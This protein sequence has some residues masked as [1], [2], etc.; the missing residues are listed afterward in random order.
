MTVSAPRGDGSLRHDAPAPSVAI[1]VS[2]GIVVALTGVRPTGHLVVDVVET[3][4]GVAI[5]VL[6]GARAPWWLLV[7]AA[8]LAGAVGLSMWPVVV[9]V[10][11]FALAAWVSPLDHDADAR[12]DLG[13]VSVG[14]TLIAFAL[15]NLETFTGASAIAGIGA[16]LALVAGGLMHLT[17]PTRRRLL[18]ATGVVVLVGAVATA[19]L[20]YA[21]LG[22]RDDLRT[23]VD[24]AR[25][26]ARL[27]SDLESEAGANEMR[28]AGA[29][30]AAANGRLAAWYTQPARLVPIVAQHRRAGAD[31]TGE[32]AEQ[33]EAAASDL[34]EISLDGLQIT[35]GT[36]DIASVEALAAPVARFGD[37][38]ERLAGLVDDV[39][40]PW[41]IDAVRTRVGNLDGELSDLLPHIA[42]A[43][44][45]TEVL[46]EMLGQERA[47]HYLVLF[48]TPSEARG[49]GG[50]IG[51]YAVM[52]I[53]GGRLAVATTGRRS[54][55]ERSAVAAGATLSGPP[56]LLTRYGKFGLGGPDGGPVGP[57][58]WSNLTLEP[59]WPSFA[60]AAHELY[61]SSHDEP[62]DGV[63]VMDP[64]VL[65]QLS[66]YT[67]PIETR[68]GRNL[69]GR[70]LVDHVLLGQYASD[71]RLDELEVLS[72][73]LLDAI[74]RATLPGPVELVR[75]LDPLIDEQRLR[76]WSPDADEQELFQ[77]VGVGDGLPALA[78]ADAFSLA[79]N[80]AG[81][82][83]I[84]AFLRTTTDVRHVDGPDGPVVRATVELHN[85]A[86]GEGYTDYVIGNLLDLPTGTSR[87][88]LVAYT[89]D[90]VESATVDGDSVAV[91]RL[92]DDGWRT[93]AHYVEIGPSE[94]A[95]VVYE[96]AARAPDSA[97]LERRQPLAP[98]E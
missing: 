32:V 62:V 3:V 55:L 73:R 17:R 52:S 87:L 1:A 64:W 91:E 97:I 5:V 27:T 21:A 4:L 53:D 80:N 86:P 16:S 72:A 51:N 37:R 76:V 22:A 95:T 70:E 45:A 13:A 48:T 61:N 11:A 26:S 42:D 46:P 96:F 36:I 71:S 68:D 75:E 43:E 2:A 8:G 81:G 38:I 49:L 30:L 40:S 85:T 24:R 58:S 15:S 14:L 34:D 12:T 7:G 10:T 6:V 82:S 19:A 77:S 56:G 50:F 59:D 28:A 18:T 93:A 54:E 9:A 41:L 88:Y 23:G 25:E 31:L 94:R 92:V 20:A 47:K 67:G 60:T 66:V 84:D 65:G 78:D 39:D 90:L 33:L 29:D 83:K 63:I 44:L 35:A 98:R 57:R 74:L 69:A 79:I 89:S